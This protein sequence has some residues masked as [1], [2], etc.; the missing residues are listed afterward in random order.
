MTPDPPLRL[1]CVGHASVDFAFEV[2][3]FPPQPTKVVA[4]RFRQRLGGMG[5]NAAIAASRLGASVRLAAP[6]GDDEAAAYV[7][8]RLADE[9]IDASTLVRVPGASTSVSTVIVDGRG[10]RLIVGHRGSSLRRAPPL[11]TASLL[12]GADMLLADPR[13]ISFARAAL[14]SARE[15]SV[16]CML[17]GDV[18]PRDDLR[19]LVALAD[20]AVFSEPGLAAY[21][22]GSVETALARALAAGPQAVVVTRGERGLLWQRRGMPSPQSLPAFDVGPAKDTTGAGDVFHGAL[23]VALGE[24]RA[25][26]E[27]LRFASAAAALK[28]LHADG[29]AGAP[30]RE[31]VLE[32]LARG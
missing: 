20:W 29:I 22:D 30:R 9:R 2:E 12:A 28:C 4:H 23:A 25:D 1:V 8:R 15:R 31:A 13:C 18:A 19:A 3:A 17:D 16:P 7:A 5:A 14:A 26:V 24:G 32:L 21:D 11:D 27:A 6:L 10:E